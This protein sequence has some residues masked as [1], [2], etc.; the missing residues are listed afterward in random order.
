M[1]TPSEVPDT[2]GGDGAETAES[3]LVKV[4]FDLTKPCQCSL[5]NSMSTDASPLAAASDLDKY[6]GRRPWNK[7]RKISYQE[8]GQED[9]VVYRVAEGRLCLI[10]RNVF[11][12]MGLQHK[13]G[14]TKEY[15]QQ[16]SGSGAKEHEKFMAGMKEWIAQH[17][18]NPSRT[19]LK[20]VKSV[21]DAKP[22]MEAKQRT[23]LKIKAPEREFVAQSNWNPQ[24]DGEW[25]ESKAETL[26]IAGVEVRGCYKLPKRAGVYKIEEYVDS[27]VDE[28]R[29][30][31]N[32]DTPFADAA[33]QEARN[34]TQQRW[35][36][37]RQE[38]DKASVAAPS[39]SSSGGLGGL[40]LDDVLALLQGQGSLE[41]G[42][43]LTKVKEEATEP[44]PEEEEEES[45]DEENALAAAT[46]AFAVRKP[47]AKPAKPKPKPAAKASGKAAAKPAAAPAAGSAPSK[48]LPAALHKPEPAESV[49]PVTTAFP[50]TPAGK[51]VPS[52]RP[53]GAGAGVKREPAE[54]TEATGLGEA[55]PTLVLDGR[56]QR[57][58]ESV[59]KSLEEIQGDLQAMEFS[60]DSNLAAEDVKK[61]RNRRTRALQRIA[62]SLKTHLKR[63]QESA[64]RAALSAQESRIEE[65]QE[66]LG[67]LQSL[68]GSLVSSNPDVEEMEAALTK[69]AQQRVEIK[70]AV[71]A[72][73]RF[74]TLKVGRFM[75]Y[76][77]Y[78]Q[79]VKLFRKDAPEL[80]ALFRELPASAVEDHVVL[81]VSNRMT[82]MMRNI[83]Q[84][85]AA[86]QESDS[87]RQVVCFCKAIMAECRSQTGAEESGSQTGSLLQRVDSTARLVSVL[88]DGRQDLSALA[89]CLEQ[90]DAYAQLEEGAELGD[91]E[92]QCPVLQ[93]FVEHK[94]G[95]TLVGHAR[96]L[97]AGQKQDARVQQQLAEVEDG[98][99]QLRQLKDLTAKALR[100]LVEPTWQK[101]QAAKKGAAAGLKV[102][103]ESLAKRFMEALCWKTINELQEA[104]LGFLDY[105]SEAHE[106]GG[107]VCSLE[108]EDPK[109]GAKENLNLGKALHELNHVQNVMSNFFKQLGDALPQALQEQLQKDAFVRGHLSKL[110]TFVF[111]QQ[112]LPS[113][114]CLQPANT[115]T[116][117]LALWA[118]DLQLAVSEILPEAEDVT[119]TVKRFFGSFQGPAV[120]ELSSRELVAYR[121]IGSLAKLCMELKTNAN[122]AEETVKRLLAQ[123]PAACPLQP[124]WSAFLELAKCIHELQNADSPLLAKVSAAIQKFD[125]ALA[126]RDV[127]A[128]APEKM[129]A[130]QLQSE[131]F[132]KFLETARERKRQLLQGQVRQRCTAACEAALQ[133]ACVLLQV[134]NPQADEVAYRACIASSVQVGASAAAASRQAAE[135][136]QDLSTAWHVCDAELR[137]LAERA[138]TEARSVASLLAAHITFFAALTLLRSPEAGARSPEGKAV[139]KKMDALLQSFWTRDF[140]A[141]P[142]EAN[143][144]HEYV[145]VVLRDMSSCIERST[146]KCCVNL[147]SPDADCW[148]T[149]SKLSALSLRTSEAWL[150]TQTGAELE[151]AQKKIGAAAVGQESS[152]NVVDSQSESEADRDRHADAD[153]GEPQ[154]PPSVEP[155]AAPPTAQ[156]CVPGS[157][158]SDAAQPLP[159]S[160]NP[161][162]DTESEPP[163]KRQKA[164]QGVDAPSLSAGVATVGPAGGTQPDEVAATVQHEDKEK[165]MSSLPASS[166]GEETQGQD[167]E[168]DA[169][170]VS[171]PEEVPSQA[172][173]SDKEETQAEKPGKR[174]AQEDEED[175]SKAKKPEKKGEGQEREEREEREERKEGQREEGE[176][177]EEGEAAEK[178]E[179]KE[180]E[181]REINENKEAKA[182]ELQFAKGAPAAGVAKDECSWAGRAQSQGKS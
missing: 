5:C 59:Q 22:K 94:I 79:A 121:E 36:S 1:E 130:M 143:F 103:A 99:A 64:N 69:V 52:K 3:S 76:R 129:A 131:E 122:V 80:Q 15:F 75:L 127:A 81:E 134:P 173:P 56:G 151:K 176:K 158:S 78:D 29:N 85:E 50:K 112:G 111:V 26:V 38:R 145:L 18:D 9:A 47:K 14:S 58:Q 87:K 40:A 116:E 137:A 144:P 67:A 120:A 135:A 82:S 43:A 91:A 33:L 160:H 32:S 51:Q 23:G 11:C 141:T 179:G 6:A 84:T 148:P 153:A 170:R 115:T 123:L 20:D 77:Q 164:E 17:N 156:E 138:V 37:G 65:L 142:P 7:Y 57:L 180:G 114:L 93:F 155:A 101:L 27:S 169:V 139:G 88:L 49:Q 48:G 46:S 68:N 55:A 95:T 146:G 89:S 162:P 42:S 16:I 31:Q 35:H 54:A 107:W 44:Q 124:I 105:V 117:D 8:E 128:K 174:K 110:C 108:S 126:K 90:V 166:T 39:S 167:K 86:K 97:V 12:A 168:E 96:E 181:K 106:C 125:D 34:A 172:A 118:G 74:H 163:N 21:K 45:E 24:L 136:L 10:C 98:I 72:H 177:G 41:R 70:F 4:R 63:V 159:Q 161:E 71:D 53:G 60:T 178:E 113:A 171:A 19:R 154:Q 104:M 182:P 152:Q 100:E 2:E 149:R 175:A 102:Q 61:T 157:Q 109:S 13:Y 140:P 83:A 132:L 62:S 30:L 25:D 119:A 66:L 73:C 165:A 92:D 147:Q 150:K 28:T 133:C